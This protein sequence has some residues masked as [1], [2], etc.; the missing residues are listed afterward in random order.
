MFVSIKK[1]NNLRLFGSSKTNKWVPILCLPL[2]SFHHQ[3]TTNATKTI[4]HNKENTVN[5]NRISSSQQ[6]SCSQ[7]NALGNWRMFLQVS[8][9]MSNWFSCYHSIAT[10]TS[11]TFI[12]PP[13]W[14][15]ASDSDSYSLKPFL[16]YMW[17]YQYDM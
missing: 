14:N 16:K 10:K 9:S 2:V 17:T 3:T 15:G 11:V 7:W 13:L 6:H 5:L 12:I 8:D 4:K 1:K